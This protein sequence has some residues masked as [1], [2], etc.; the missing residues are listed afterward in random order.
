MANHDSLTTGTVLN[1]R[2]RIEE[3]LGA[4]GYSEVVAAFD[5]EHQRR[6][7][8]KVLHER[9][10]ATDPRAVARLRQEAEILRAIEHPHIVDIF[11]V[12]TFAGGQFLVM[13]YVD[14]VGLDTV[15]AEQAPLSTDRLLP[16]I[17]QLLR[18]LRAAHDT[19][20]LH[21]DLKPQNILVVDGEEG[22][23]I[24]LV[25]FGVA[26]VNS[27]LN[28]DDPDEGV[29]LVRTQAGNFVGTP[30]YAAPEV[31]VG[32]PPAPNSDLFGVGAIAFEALTGHPLID[33]KSQS[34]L[35]NQLVFPRPFDLSEVPEP[36]PQWLAPI[37]EKSPDQ[38]ILSADE[39]LELMD[40]VFG[41]SDPA[42]SVNDTL[43]PVF[44]DHSSAAQLE[45]TR[46][47]ESPLIPEAAY[48]PTVERQSLID[49]EAPDIDESAPSV[50][51]HPPQNYPDASQGGDTASK[52]QQPS[53]STTTARINTV[54]T[55][56]ILAILAF[57]LGSLALAIR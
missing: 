52:Q 1:E 42:E 2:Y 15:L 8:L 17:R 38:R 32:D 13:E 40:H 39:A 31:V 41:N 12:D 45:P 34:E 10:T 57:V 53:P 51:V 46:E 50:D 35:M 11:D 25:D 56:L 33:G 48:A 49:Q 21:R 16:M 43:H 18:A 19:Q 29:T 54:L 23:S 5:L 44:S 7:A 27:L 47:V 14:G 22:E 36:W 26:K 30:R 4:G 6:V 55:F 24:K 28:T 37:L 20:I 9:A 3:H